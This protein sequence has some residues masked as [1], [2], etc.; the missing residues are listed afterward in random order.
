[1]AH[2]VKDSVLETST[3]TGAGNFTLSGAVT[4]YRTFASVCSIND[5]FPYYIEAVDGSGIPTGSW[6]TG[7]GTYSGTNTLTRTSVLDSSNSGSAVSFSSGTKRVGIGA[8]SRMFGWTE[9]AS[10][11]PAA[12]SYVTFDNIPQIYQ[13]LRIV[14]L[15]IGFS[16][17]SSSLLRLSV[18]NSSG[19]V[20]SSLNVV[21]FTAGQTVYGG[22]EFQA[23]RNDAGVL[24]RG[25]NALSADG[26]DTNGSGHTWR[27][28]GGI[29][30]I[31]FDFANDTSGI[32]AGTA[33][34]Y[35]R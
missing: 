32:D 6:E 5:T 25:Y 11:T 12:D 18:K 13:D 21:N 30:G 34:L 24:L 8:V 7:I 27:C 31:R 19:W 2:I 22:W 9:I 4:G 10:V 16:A 17:G 29:R 20:A 35:V 14:L 26:F 33:K 23:Y 28:V 3:T 1:M 15:G